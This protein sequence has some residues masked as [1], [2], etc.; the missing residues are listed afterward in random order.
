MLISEQ[1]FVKFGLRVI[2]IRKQDVPKSCPDITQA[3]SLTPRVVHAWD[4]FLSSVLGMQLD[5][6]SVYALPS[7]FPG[8]EINSVVDLRF[9]FRDDVGSVQ[10]L[11][12]FAATSSTYGLLYGVPD[13]ICSC[14]GDDGVPRILFPIQM[15]MSNVL[16]LTDGVSFHDEYCEQRSGSEGPTGALN[17]LYRYMKLNGY[18][19]GVLST[20]TQTWFVMIEGNNDDEILVSPTISFTGTAPTLQQCYLWL[21]R[22]ASIDGRMNVD[23]SNAQLVR[24]RKFTESNRRVERRARNLLP[25]RYNHQSH[26]CSSET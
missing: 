7:Y 21:I 16:Q 5:N 20:Y 1:D 24:T 6:Q 10:S 8:R 3:F 2:F 9:I 13:L 18:R 11:P 14:V 4:A 12:P 22:A 19:Y 17:Q 15:E 25:R 23:G 26:S